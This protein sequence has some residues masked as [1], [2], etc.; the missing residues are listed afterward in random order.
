MFATKKIKNTITE[1]KQLCVF[2]KLLGAQ[3]F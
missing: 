3:K 1:K 2:L